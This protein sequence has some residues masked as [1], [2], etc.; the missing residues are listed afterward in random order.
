MIVDCVSIRGKSHIENGIPCQ[1]SS[2]CWSR[3]DSS[4]IAVSDGHGNPKYARSNLGSKIA[5]QG[6]IE[7]I[8]NYVSKRSFKKRIVEEPDDTIIEIKK[9]IIDYWNN[10]VKADIF[11]KDE[12]TS[13]LRDTHQV[14]IDNKEMVDEINI[15]KKK[16]KKKNNN[17]TI[18]DEIDA[19][20]DEK[21]SDIKQSIS[22]GIINNEWKDELRLDIIKKLETIK[23]EFANSKAEGEEKN[24]IK[25]TIQY[26]ER[27]IDRISNIK[28]ETQINME[29]YGATLAVAVFSENYV[30]GIQI[31]DGGIFIVHSDGRIN[32]ALK[33][34]P[35]CKGNITTSLCDDDPLSVFHHFYKQKKDIVGS[36]VC[37]DGFTNCYDSS[38]I[39]CPIREIISRLDVTNKWHTSTIPELAILSEK[40]NKDDVSVSVCCDSDANYQ[41]FESLCT[42]CIP[43]LEH[44][45]YCTPHISKVRW[46]CNVQNNKIIEMGTLFDGFRYLE[47]T[48]ENGLFKEGIIRYPLPNE[49]INSSGIE[50]PEGGII[51]KITDKDN[52]ITISSFKDKLSKL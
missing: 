11:E 31:G 13:A 3:G 16:L 35:R 52:Y 27:I 40:V 41:L 46:G 25:K 36:F 22:E 44:D 32:L 50:M 39:Q 47:G 48:F 51:L 5:I 17:W 7:V 1:D 38:E 9:K 45:S 8:S 49:M 14:I 12:W 43:E 28:Y 21:K 42:H 20:F 26:F 29:Q 10:N 2:G 4:I 24:K 30:F 33:L 37:T 15:I 18:T 34:D 23:T 6:S 19:I